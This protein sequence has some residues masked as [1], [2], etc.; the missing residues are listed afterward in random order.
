MRAID[1]KFKT[2]SLVATGSG[3]E[4]YKDAVKAAMLT[5]NA[6]VN[7]QFE[8]KDNGV[9]ILSGNSIRKLDK[10]TVLLKP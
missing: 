1:L 10:Q 9:I 8:I 5:D 3:Y 7:A 6:T 4:S 2:V